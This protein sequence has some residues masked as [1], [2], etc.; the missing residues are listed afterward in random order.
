MSKREKA[1]E[2]L[3]LLEQTSG[4]DKI[5]RRIIREEWNIEI[6]K[7]AL[8]LL[9]KVYQGLKEKYENPPSDGFYDLDMIKLLSDKLTAIG[10]WRWKLDDP[11][12]QEFLPE[13]K[14]DIVRT[15]VAY[16]H[17]IIISIKENREATDLWSLTA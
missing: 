14:E 9:Q 12:T 2:L 13:I 6:M 7:E 1:L 4:C 11:I 17:F 8:D 15:I 10:Y 5:L 16:Y 3:E